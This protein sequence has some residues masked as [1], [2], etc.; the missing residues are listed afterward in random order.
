[1]CVILCVKC[2]ASYLLCSRIRCVCVCVF[3]LMGRQ[4]ERMHHQFVFI[5][6][7]NQLQSFRVDSWIETL[8]T[9]SCMDSSRVCPNKQVS[10]SEALC[11]CVWERETK[12]KELSPFGVCVCVKISTWCF[13]LWMFFDLWHHFLSR[14]LAT[15]LKP[16]MSAAPDPDDVISRLKWKLSACFCMKPIWGRSFTTCDQS[17]PICKSLETIVV[18]GKL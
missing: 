9:L 4:K 18:S 7:M 16:R 3:S 2:L 6:E 15:A 8:N 12:H 17:C 10:G 14:Y 5:I 1:M 11:V 13:I